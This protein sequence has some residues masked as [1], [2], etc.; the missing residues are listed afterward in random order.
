MAQGRSTKIITMIKWIRTSRLSI[1]NSL[2]LLCFGRPPH[3]TL[4]LTSR[5]C[6][7]RTSRYHTVD[8]EWVIFGGL[9]FNFTYV[10]AWQVQTWSRYTRDQVIIVGAVN[11]S[12]STEY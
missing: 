2:S 5:P 4:R 9:S 1:K 10:S 7:R 3:L 8:S 11:H 12:Q 6:G